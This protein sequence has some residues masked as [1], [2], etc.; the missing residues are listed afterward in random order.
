MV[1]SDTAKAKENT[2][3]KSD[4]DSCHRFSDSRLT[5]RRTLNNERQD[6]ARFNRVGSVPHRRALRIGAGLLDLWA[7]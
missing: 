6:T 2:A 3:K 4:I 5:F 7:Q 1:V